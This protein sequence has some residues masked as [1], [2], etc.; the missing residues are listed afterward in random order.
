MAIETSYTFRASAKGFAEVAREIDKVNKTAIEGE[1]AVKRAREQA[2]SGKGSLPGQGAGAAGMP[3]PGSRQVNLPPGVVWRPGYGPKIGPGSTPSGR[4]PK[5]SDDGDP[6]KPRSKRGLKGDPEALKLLDKA[7]RRATASAE[8]LVS[9]V[10]D[11]NSAI[12]DGLPS[13]REYAGLYKGT[14]GG[15]GGTGGG[16]GGGG[17]RGPRPP[18]LPSG[19][20]GGERRSALLQGLLEGLLPGIGMLQ[21]GGGI[22]QQFGGRVLGSTVRGAGAFARNSLMAPFSGVQGVQNAI[23]SVPLVGGFLG[24][25]SGQM[26][27]NAGS[28]IGFEGQ[29]MANLPYL[30]RTGVNAANL[31]G[32]GR[33]G[34]GNFNQ[35][36]Q[37]GLRNAGMTGQQ[38]QQFLASLAQSSGG[39]ADN[40]LVGG[41][42]G[43]ALSAF[44]RY[45]VG[46]E[47]SGLFAQ[48][49]RLQGGPGTGTDGFLRSLATAQGGL[50]L[51]G[52]ELQDYMRQMAE[53]IA[54]FKDTGIPLRTDTIG[55]LGTTLASSGIAGA[56]AGSMSNAFV[57]NA[58]SIGMDGPQS[59][60]DLALLQAS[61]GKPL[62]GID[63]VL[64]AR[65]ALE[66]GLS[67][68]QMQRTFR[69]LRDIGKQ[70]YG[71]D[72]Y[73]KS[74]QRQFLSSFGIKLNSKE[75]RNLDSGKESSLSDAQMAGFNQNLNQGAQENVS[76]VIQKQSGL[77]NAN[78]NLGMKGL[79]TYFAAEQT[80]K[81]IANGVVEGINPY[82]KEV[83]RAITG[84]YGYVLNTNS[85]AMASSPSAG[86]T[87]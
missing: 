60:E 14:G 5:A 47:V 35:L 84:L 76:S 34:M 87:R 26:F 32:R 75:F 21:R 54:S 17:G 20:G 3:Q 49:A 33:M 63:D 38:S 69:N 61:A 19:G 16:S 59:F 81:A 4:L 83:T 67:P 74:I 43:S 23:S 12:N 44:S 42:A 66:Q 9:S 46:P 7:Y 78:L 22:M 70:S 13:F 30:G 53:D 51:A 71:N 72:R 39:T 85:A 27:S 41:M 86:A 62:T 6:T 25:A 55:A 1:K 29:Q 48:G 10:M 68:K 79:D 31:G 82:V 58:Q 40:P 18:G 8:R 50:G 77:D 36:S 57:R 73:G 80:S 45:G 64:D 65:E 24:A 2:M 56:R 52:T 28:A 11:V 37:M 15:G